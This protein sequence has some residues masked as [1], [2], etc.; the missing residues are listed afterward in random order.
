MS[1]FTN[2]LYLFLISLCL[3]SA[4]KDKNSNAC[5][6][7]YEPDP[8]G[9][10]F[11]GDFHVH[12]TGAS[13]DTGSIPSYPADIKQKA[14]ERGLDFLVLT[15]HSNSTGSDPSTTAED[16]ALFNQGPEFPYWKECAALTDADF[17]MIDGNEISPRH[18]DQTIPTGHIGCLPTNLET[19]DTTVVFI[20]RPMGSVTGGNTVQQAKA[21]GCF[22]IVNHPYSITKH[23]AYDWTSYDY[24]GMEIWNGTIGYDFQ[25]QDGRDAWLC[26]LLNGKPTVAVG[27]SDC[28][29]AYIDAPGSGFDPALGFPTTAVFADKLEWPAIMEGLKNGK[30]SIFGGES[31]L[32]IDGY[33]EA[34]C[35]IESNQTKYLRIRGFVDNNIGIATLTV[36]RAINCTDNRPDPS[37]GPEIQHETLYDETAILDQAFDIRIPINGES[38]VYSAILLGETTS[39]Y[40]AISRAIVIP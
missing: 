11:N 25:D 30:T 2:K 18:P 4:C 24:D 13:N 26:D 14:I 39:H 29:R 22:A 10:W 38:G 5:G 8:P 35:R 36:T 3:L 17:L 40:N 31:R 23:I 28:H 20:D 15:D 9:Q 33:D 16:P 1:V 27:G 19:F 21:A 34:F 37:D 12:A 7:D 32:F 6:D